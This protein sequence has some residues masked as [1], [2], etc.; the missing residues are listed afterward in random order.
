MVLLGNCLNVHYVILEI[1]SALLAEISDL[2]LFEDNEVVVV[3]DFL[4]DFVG[5][6]H[7]HFDTFCQVV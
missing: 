1:E 7:S 3:I 5:M 4:D 6:T 2:P